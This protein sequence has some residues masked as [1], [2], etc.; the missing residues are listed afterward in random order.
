[1]KK[2]LVTVA[3]TAVLSSTFVS[4]V[5]ASTYK[6][7][8]GDSLWSIARKHDTSVTQLKSLNK[9]QSDI[10][11]PNQVL[12][13]VDSQVNLPAETP[14]QSQEPS[15][16]PS[17]KTYTIKAGDTLIGIA[18]KHS[19]TLA[20]LNKWNSI[21][22]HI[23]YPGQ[24]LVISA[25]SEGQENSN[26]SEIPVTSP[27]PP[28]SE[29]PENTASSY[30]VKP[31]DTLTH[32]SIKTGISVAEIKKL[33]GLST[34][35]IYAG[36]GLMLTKSPQKETPAVNDEASSPNSYTETLLNEAKSLL[37]TPYVWGG[38]ALGGF[39]CSGFIYYVYNK[40]GKNINRLSSGGYYNRSFYVNKPSVGDLVFFEN[41]Y[42]KGISHLGIYVG[43]DKF[44]HAGDNGV[45][46]TSLNHSYWKSKFD[47]FKRFY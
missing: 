35:M 24:K 26:S 34:D 15:A 47:G 1:M 4:E 39:D 13:I 3:A 2:T 12:K 41:T 8:S 21:S 9:I 30:K 32:I 42:K 25:A 36:Q 33:N 40:A 45:E 29:T 10:I 38:S 5:A 6:V 27:V 44:I 16:A 31:G 19:I 37:G 11:Y 7:Q 17:A 46:I 18:N 43:N 22:S 23:I 20:E 28:S 14:T